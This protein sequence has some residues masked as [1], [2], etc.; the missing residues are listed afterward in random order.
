MVHYNVFIDGVK[1]NDYA[2]DDLALQA[3]C[4][5]LLSDGVLEEEIHIVEI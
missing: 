4:D 2:L 3:I 1:V 5:D